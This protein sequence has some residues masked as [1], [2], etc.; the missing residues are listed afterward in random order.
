MEDDVGVVQY[1]GET[2]VG[3]IGVGAKVEVVFFLPM[4]L[5]PGTVM[6]TNFYSL[7]TPSNEA[8]R[9]QFFP[10]DPPLFNLCNAILP[11][12]HSL[13]WKFN[14]AQATTAENA[15]KTESR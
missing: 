11:I 6:S 3:K 14:R 4:T 1:V 10:K 15:S 7:S 8:R 12:H 2:V 5:R 9:R 13:V